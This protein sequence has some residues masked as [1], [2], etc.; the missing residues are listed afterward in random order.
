MMVYGDPAFT[1]TLGSYV[2]QLEQDA[3]RLNDI[4]SWRRILIAIGCLEQAIADWNDSP[5]PEAT[6]AHLT[7]QA[8][9]GFCSHP[10]NWIRC[11]YQSHIKR[12]LQVEIRSYS[13]QIIADGFNKT[14]KVKVPEGF[15]FY[16]L[17]P[18]QYQA[19][20]LDW[21]RA[22]ASDRSLPVYVVGLR[23]IGTTLSAIVK[24]VLDSQG[25]NAQRVTARPVE[26][27]FCRHT[28][29]PAWIRPPGYLLAV[30]E[31]PG[32]SG[33][34]F[35]SVARAGQE[36]GFPPDT[37]SFFTSHDNPPGGAASSEI[38][39]LWDVIPRWHVPLSDFHDQLHDA[40]ARRSADFPGFDNSFQFQ[41]D[42]SAGNWRQWISPS[43]REHVMVFPPFEKTKWLFQN[44]RGDQVLWKFTGLTFQHRQN[45]NCHSSSLPVLHCHGFS[46]HPWI[47][48]PNL[49][50]EAARDSIIIESLAMH[51]ASIHNPPLAREEHDEALERLKQMIDYNASFI[52]S[53]T[54]I[55]RAL[56]LA[57]LVDYSP[58]A[59][60]RG[61]GDLFPQNWVRHENGAL[62]KVDLP[63]PVC[64]HT[65]IGSQPW[66]WDLAGLIVEWRLSSSHLETLLD[67][68]EQKGR[69]I[70]REVLPFYI[71]AYCAFRM[72]QLN[73]PFVPQMETHGI[74]PNHYHPIFLHWIRSG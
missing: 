33:S 30:D 35:A 47:T 26:H 15:A 2:Q 28:D 69:P 18:E 53:K 7:D 39:A 63:V 59:P 48:S 74:A 56:Q 49:Q 19:A 73:W 3:A 27:P 52:F 34:S 21:S 62:V 43:A 71:C 45:E 67:C 44:D 29:L 23:S 46:G 32:L 50:P 70:P 24:A 37:I 57:D 54:E 65:I 17:F 51:L 11:D 9:A 14:L 10:E 20:A 5:I 12:H 68:L 61:A 22:H 25:W 55:E 72:G 4:D 41:A 1:V 6:I 40:L 8:A 58:H 13:R 66:F 36:R 60:A 31:G 16:T 38:K 42:L 64:D